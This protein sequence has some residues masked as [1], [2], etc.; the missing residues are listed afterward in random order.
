MAQYIITNRPEEIN[1][2]IGDDLV[3]RTIQNAKNLLMTR[4]GD[5]PYDRLRG[6]DHALFH[7]PFD[8]MQAALLPEIERVMLWEPDAEVISAKA[9]LDEAGEVVVS[10]KIEVDFEE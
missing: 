3:S 10:V 9:T 4:M 1:F 6:F 8:K 5:V 2:E 7:L